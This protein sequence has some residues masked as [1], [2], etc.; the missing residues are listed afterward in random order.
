[1]S[2]TIVTPQILDFYNEDADSGEGVSQDLIFKIIQAMQG[3][4][5][6]NVE[7]LGSLEISVMPELN[8]QALKS[9][10]FVLAK[11]QDVTNTDY[12]QYLINNGLASGTIYLPDMRGMHLVGLNSGRSDG[13]QHHKN[14]S[15]GG[16]VSGDIKS[17]FHRVAAANLNIGASGS[18]VTVPVI[19]ENENDAD[20][21]K[22]SNTG[23]SQNTVNA[24][25]VNY[26][27]KVWNT[28][29]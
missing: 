7:A 2:G 26:F 6:N 20:T 17:H 27:I 16:F 13:N 14:P 25:G 10:A 22:T 12:G 18:G 21:G 4:K 15:L 9:N 11:G 1:M 24:I 8:F 29:Q 5:V 19:T 3:L 23:N 28:P